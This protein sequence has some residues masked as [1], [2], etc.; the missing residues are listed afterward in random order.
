MTN[1]GGERRRGGEGTGKEWRRGYGR[2]GKGFRG[3]ERTGRE[4]RE[5]GRERGKGRG[6]VC[7]L[8]EKRVA[9]GFFGCPHRITLFGSR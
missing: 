7:T 6:E 9:K 5:E 2:R 4:V 1:G 3:G 8:L